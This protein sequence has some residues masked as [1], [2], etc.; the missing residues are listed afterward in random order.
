MADEMDF[1]ASVEVTVNSG[2]AVGDISAIVKELQLLNKTV[3]ELDK[4]AKK[5]LDEVTEGFNKGGKAAK[6]AATGTETLTKASTELNQA[7]GIQANQLPRLRYALYDV[8]SSMAVLSAATLGAVTAALTFSAKF[9]TAFTAIERTTMG[10]VGA[11]GLLRKQLIALSL[12]TPIAFEELAK[13]TSLGSQL[14]IASNDLIGF[15]KV[16]SEFAA[17][18]NVSTDEAAK[19]FGR[20][21][22]LLGVLPAD[23]KNLGSAIALVGVNS[24]ATETEILRTSIG[25]AGVAKTAGLSTEFVIGLAGSLASLGVPA[26]QSRGALTRIFQEI[27]RAAAD[28]GPVLDSFAQVLGKTS[29]QAKTLAQSDLEGFFGEL[30]VG[31]NG[32]SSGELTTALDALN[33]A[34]IRVTNTLSRLATNVEFTNGLIGDSASAFKDGTF[35]AY[36]YGLKVDDLASRFQILQNSLA[37]LFA[38]VGDS[39]SPFAKTLIDFLSGF[40]NGLTALAKTPAGAVLL[41]LNAILAILVG[42]I[43]AVVG[44]LALFGASIAAT[45][46]ALITMGVSADGAAL[47]V[48]R[49]GTAFKIA[50]GVGIVLLLAE[51]VGSLIAVGMAAEDTVAKFTSFVNDTSGLSEALAADAK[52]RDEAIAAGGASAANAFIAVSG[53]ASQASPEIQKLQD[54]LASTADLLNV[55]VPAGYDATN[56]AIS[57]N[58][59]YVGENTIAW[60]RNAL[61]VSD[62]FRELASQELIPFSGKS[63]SDTLNDIGLNFDEFTRRIIKDGEIGGQRYLN[64]LSNAAYQAGKIDLFTKIAL[65]A[66]SSI[67]PVSEFINLIR[68][69]GGVLATIGAGSTGIGAG[70]EY[71][72]K[73]FNNVSNAVPPVVKAVRTLVDY[74]NDLSGVFKRAFDIRWQATLNADATADSWENLSKRIVEA[75]NKILNLTTTRDKLEYFLSIAVK[76]GDTIRINEL[77]AQLA[78]ANSDLSSATDDAST[79]LKG[80]STAARKNRRE[81]LGIIQGNADY[82]TSLAA[83]GTS[84]KKLSEVA[85]Q[86]NQDFI[87]QATAMGY[88]GDEVDDFAKSFADFSTIIK[89]VPRDITVSANANPALQALNEFVAEANA[90]SATVT[91]DTEIKGD[92][93]AATIKYLQGLYDSKKAL[94]LQQIEMKNYAGAIK[95]ADFM[96]NYASEIRELGGV[97]AYYSGG[98][99]G[100]GGKYEPAGIVHRGEY[101]VPKSQVNQSTGL[102]YADAMGRMMPPSAPAASSYANGGF[103]TGGMMVSLS[104]DDRALLRAVGASGDIVVAVDS[105]EIARA[106]ARGARLVTAE[107]GYLV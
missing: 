87:D 2:K 54:Q 55:N 83:N 77:T 12:E 32:M 68:G 40:V 42:V 90:A 103:V 4:T 97:V 79:S 67:G 51:I 65:Q 98:F 43:A 18:T 41:T 84:Q 26:E 104:P 76:A 60:I 16:V 93:V 33:L 13:I 105:R 47:A 82:L 58:T 70:A 86:L 7:Q 63:I 92:R 30:L 72:A 66:S 49:L 52:L 57:N 85:S 3:A 10:S 39:I 9:E 78:D 45:K 19:G 71:M 24:A 106:N 53:A 28:G 69:Y 36:A 100:R 1:K 96:S 17:V 64:E 37:A 99:T 23:Y 50:S 75:R 27:N 101:V 62:K 22:E 48:G 74:A 29:A 5:T 95:S 107:G 59:R 35:L 21:G 56:N 20:L 73:Q 25:L 11:I 91:I 88:S 61:I 38:A 15:T 6:V 80:N 31:L 44:S 89:K 81:L 14:G 8:A 46:T 34:D 102:P 94:Y